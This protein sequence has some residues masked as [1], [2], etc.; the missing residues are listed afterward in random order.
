[1]V[2]WVFS[3]CSKMG[4]IDISRPAGSGCRKKEKKDRIVLD[5]CH[6]EFMFEKKFRLVLA[7]RLPERNNVKKCWETG[8]RL[9]KSFFTTWVKYNIKHKIS[10]SLHTASEDT[11]IYNFGKGLPNIISRSCGSSSSILK[12]RRLIDEVGW[13]RDRWVGQWIGT[14]CPTSTLCLTDTSYQPQTQSQLCIVSQPYCCCFSSWN[15]WRQWELEA[16][17][18]LSIVETAA[19]MAREEQGTAMG[20]GK[21]GAKV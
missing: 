14:R 1:M 20:E 13:S 15:W 3:Q 9:L 4:R 12:K 5:L 2:M 19:G 11:V 8:R 17:K 7:W 18:F 6:S 16:F 21:V 10:Y